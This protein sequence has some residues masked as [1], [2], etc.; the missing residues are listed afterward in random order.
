MLRIA[1]TGGIATGKS[2]VASRLRLAGVPLVDADILAREAVAPGAPGLAAVATRFGGDVLLPD[3]TLDRARLGTIVFGDDNARRDLEAIV[4][5]AVRRGIDDFF[6]SLPPETPFAVAD[7][8]LFY[9]TGRE[10]PFDYVIVAA[11]PRATQ[12]ER[13]MKRDALS[14]DAAE[15]RVAAQL[16]IDDKVKRADFVI[17]TSGTHERTDAQV[18]G[19]VAKLRALAA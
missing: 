14:R 17:D 12:V 9:E 7:I 10:K 4:H 16:P 15:R 8:P 6:R 13:V 5:P 3:G 11:C 18:D 19:V 2:Y 1:L